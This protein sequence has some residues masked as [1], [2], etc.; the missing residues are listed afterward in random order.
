MFLVTVDCLLLC[1]DCWDDLVIAGH[2]CSSLFSWANRSMFLVTVGCISWALLVIA[3]VL[4]YA[5]PT[6][7]CFLSLLVADCC[8]SLAGISW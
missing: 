5:G 7:L 1:F 4:L 2:C 8:V 3:A 6:L